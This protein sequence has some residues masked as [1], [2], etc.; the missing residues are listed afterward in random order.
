MIQQN[1]ENNKSLKG[2][3]SAKQTNPF[4]NEYITHVRMLQSS[5]CTRPGGFVI[6]L[7]WLTFTERAEL[8]PHRRE[9]PP[10]PQTLLLASN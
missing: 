8:G 9:R 6:A 3:L 5:F 10:D 4:A 2:P 7:R 1:M